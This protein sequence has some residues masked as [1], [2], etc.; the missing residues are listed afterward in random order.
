MRDA[1]I[2]ANR[3]P[4]RSDLFSLDTCNIP[5]LELLEQCDTQIDYDVCTL[6]CSTIPVV[7]GFPLS[8]SH[9][10]LFFSLS[11]FLSFSFSFS[12][13][14]GRN[15]PFSASVEELQ[16]EK[17]WWKEEDT[18][19]N[20]RFARHMVIYSSTRVRHAQE[21]KETRKHLLMHLLFF[22]LTYIHNLN[23]YT[24]ITHAQNILETKMEKTRWRWS[25]ANADAIRGKKKNSC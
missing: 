3:Y 11:L 15:R 8:I 12:R 22:S 21:E 25:L 4:N 2:E 19:R 6:T 10:K 1:P 7:L 9:S 14:R 16:R 5:N 17:R 23:T 24:Y 18:L 13:S 20:E